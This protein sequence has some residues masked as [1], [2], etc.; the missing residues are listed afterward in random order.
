MDATNIVNTTLLSVITSIGF[1]HTAILGNTLEEVSYLNNLKIASEKA[2][3]IKKN[4]PV[5]LGPNAK[6]KWVF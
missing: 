1:D 5:I 2:G 6:P 4:V 3:I